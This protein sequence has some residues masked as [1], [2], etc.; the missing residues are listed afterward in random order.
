[1]G[2]IRY[3]LGGENRRNLRRL[4]SMSDKVLALEEKYKAMSDEQLKG[5]TAELKDRL[6]NGETLDDILYDAFAVVR[7][8]A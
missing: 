1:M 6:K 2:L 8:A 7:E 5:M 3:L 4:D